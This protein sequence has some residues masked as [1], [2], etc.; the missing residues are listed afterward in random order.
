LG[1][2][3]VT[4]NLRFDNSPIE[5]TVKGERISSGRRKFGAIIGNNVQTGINVSIHPGVVIG[6]ES[7]IAPGITLQ[8]DVQG[9][10][11]KFF[12]SKLEERPL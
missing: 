6:S 12:F 2:G 7:W 4:A 9:K 1:A 5:A 11:L 8:R 10:V 3:T